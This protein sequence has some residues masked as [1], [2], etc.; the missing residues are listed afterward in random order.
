M[1]TPTPECERCG[2]PIWPERD[3]QKYCSARCREAAK[4]RRHR[5]RLRRGESLGPQGTRVTDE[6]LT[7]LAERAGPPDWRDDPRNF[8]DFGELPDGVELG[9]QLDEQTARF[10]ALVQ[11]DADRTPR[12]TWRK[13][14]AYGRRHGT[15]DP[16]QTADRIERH[17]AA[18]AARMARIDQ[19]TAGRVQDRFDPR[20]STNLARNA[21][22]SRRL[23]ARYTDQPPVM[24][25]GFDFTG[26]SFDGGPYRSGRPAG[27]RRHYSDY[28]WR[29]EDG[30]RF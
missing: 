6:S 15:E 8:S 3:G 17:R 5:F 10:H 13:W 9:R 21:N 26:Q 14:R 7:E 4:K 23:N 11:E 19:G 20:T 12:E 25:R 1:D 18:E 24:G 27:Q 2:D 30:F 29:M 28:A 16:A 22:A